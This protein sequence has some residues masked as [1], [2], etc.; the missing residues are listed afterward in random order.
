MDFSYYKS[1]CCFIEKATIGQK[2]AWRTRKGAWRYKKRAWHS[3]ILKGPRGNTTYE[4]M[5]IN[6][7]QRSRL[8]FDLSVKVP[9]IGDPST[10]LNIL[11]QKQ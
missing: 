1:D 11:F 4:T 6:K 3:A 7:F 9:H 8:T 2:K 10:C 5:A